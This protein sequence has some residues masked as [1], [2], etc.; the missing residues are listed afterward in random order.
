MNYR[1][2]KKD[3]RNKI[4]EAQ[5]NYL[6]FCGWDKNACGKWSPTGVLVTSGDT[7][8]M[9]TYNPSDKLFLKHAIEIQLNIDKDEV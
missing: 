3:L 4:I 8:S 2:N 6:I 7:N 9:F 5:E 1:I